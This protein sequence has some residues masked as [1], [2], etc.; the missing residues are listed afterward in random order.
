MTGKV[1]SSVDEAFEGCAGEAQPPQ[2]SAGEA[3]RSEGCA[4]E[5]QRSTGCAGAPQRAFPPGFVFGSATAAYQIEGA[6]NGDGKGESIWDRF[7]HEAGNVMRGETGD[8]SIDHYHRVEEDVA[9]MAELGHRSYRF[10]LSWPRLQPSGRGALNDAGASFYDRLLSAL[11]KHGIEPLV[12]LYHWDLPAALQ[13]E[14]TGFL[15]REIVPVFEQ[16]ARLCFARFGARVKRWITFNEPW[17][18]CVHGFCTGMHAPGRMGAPGVEPY[19]AA[20]HLLLAHAH[21]VRA[22]RSEFN[23]QQDGVIGITLNSEWWEPASADARDEAAA[24]RARI[25]NLAWFAD[26]VY[27]T[28]DYPDDMRRTLGLRLP[29]FSDDEKRLLK[30]SSDFFGLNH[31]STHYVGRMQAC[32]ALRTVPKEIALLYQSSASTRKFLRAIAGFAGNTYFKDMGVLTYP[33]DPTWSYTAMGWAVVPW[34]MRKLLLWVQ[35]RYQPNDILV[36]EN[37]VATP[38]DKPG[39]PFDPRSKAAQDRVRYMHDYIAEM[40]QAI[41]EGANL[42]GLWVWSTFS[43]FEWAFG[44][45]P[46]FGLID[47]DYQTLKRTPLPAAHWYKRLATTLTL[48]DVDQVEPLPTASDAHTSAE[49]RERRPDDS[50]GRRRPNAER[51]RAPG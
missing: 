44:Y 3:Q 8:V 33:D 50:G 43:N 45:A 30:G 51:R 39:E 22:F 16:Y 46:H 11:A 27:L 21:A 10:S 25:F 7:S 5:A 1:A 38:Q 47:V 9:L 41:Q 37:G 26:P 18:V 40:H 23:P 2:S 13:D 35:R 15:S 20:H 31:Y 14:F 24:Q 48:P 34:G 28:G 36:T 19:L 4:G 17:C 29:S 6:W 49:L 32:V 12:T 42:K